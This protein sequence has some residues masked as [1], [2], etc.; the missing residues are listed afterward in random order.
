MEAD[1]GSRGNPGP[2]GFGTVVRDEA[3]GE[4]VAEAAEGIGYATNNV[5]E[6]RGLIA[7]LRAARDV[8]PDAEVHVRMDSK[9]VVEQM[10]GRWKVKHPSMQPLALEAAGIFP[11]GRV[12]YA[13]IPR[14]QNRYADRLAN[15]AMDAAAK[16]RSWEA[17][18]RAGAVAAAGAGPAAAALAGEVELE[19]DEA[20]AQ[21]AGVD[22]SL[23]GSA[24]LGVAT[25][26]VLLR[27]GETRNTALK[28]FC[29]CGGADPGLSPA[30]REQATRAAK[31][32]AQR[33]GVDA[34]VASPL[35]RAQQTAAAAADALGL[36][37]RTEPGF[38]ECAFG[39]WE[40]LTFAEVSERWPAELASWL[41][42]PSVAPPGGESLEQVSSRVRVAR[43]ELITRYA[44]RT[45]LV[46]SHVTPIKVLV[47]LA[48]EAPIAALFRMELTPASLTELA[49]YADGKASLRS[50]N[51]TAHLR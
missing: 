31:A 46:V 18:P 45:V 29:G 28:R 34:V 26:T 35:L 42:D 44:G 30:G 40:G 23:V 16:G 2:A 21:P 33:G 15:E 22:A 39:A 49:W 9:L 27:H 38:A 36:D 19:V 37:V 13:W 41:G 1:G 32:L 51:E 4:V 3:T 50:Y 11:R 47:H 17:P 5:A 8:D 7:G 12:T 14:E 20:E 48:L 10:S 24:S 6:Y 25:T 43:D